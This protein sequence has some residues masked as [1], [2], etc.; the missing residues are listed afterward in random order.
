MDFKDI[1]K[2]FW[3]VMLIAFVFVVYIVALTVQTIKEKPYEVKALQKDGQSV[4]YNIGD[5]YYYANDLYD[6]L[7]S[8]FGVNQIWTSYYKSIVSNAVETTETLNNYAS[9][10]AQYYLYSYDSEQL[11]SMLKSYGYSGTDDLTNYFL[12]QAKLTTMISEYLTANYD[13]YVAPTVEQSNPKKIYHIL[14][15]VAD[16]QEVEN[17]DGTTSHVANPT[18]EESAKLNEVLKALADG[19]SFKEVATNYSEDSSASQEGLLGIVTL[20]TSNL[21]TEFKDTCDELNVGETS[22]VI[23]TTYGYHIIMAEE[24][25]VEELTSDSSFISEITNLF[26]SV[27]LQCIVDKANELGYKL[28]DETLKSQIE[29]T[30][31]SGSEVTE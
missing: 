26:P 13:K 6:D 20:N 10:M 28:Y 3:F 23:T 17:E 2:K 19:T 18:E 14:V 30:L 12:D 1:L 7:Y 29:A 16:I 15:K 27:Q 24:A 5:T 9:Y 8:N 21:V 25:T 4:V 22:E 31:A 11:A